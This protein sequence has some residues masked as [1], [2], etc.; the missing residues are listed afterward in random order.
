MFRTHLLV[1]LR[2]LNLLHFVH[3]KNCRKCHRLRRLCS[4]EGVLSSL[5]RHAHR[6][7]TKGFSGGRR[8]SGDRRRG[9]AARTGRG[10]G[11][12][13]GG[14]RGLKD[15]GSG[16]GSFYIQPPPMRVNES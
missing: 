5:H 7:C 1:L 4:E 11:G 2:S 9:A 10:G 15:D 3:L 16:V 6:V 8:E 14:T 13:G 12:W